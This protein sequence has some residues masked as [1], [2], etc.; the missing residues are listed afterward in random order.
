MGRKKKR[1]AEDPRSRIFCYYCDRNFQTE[2]ML[3][4]HQR[5]KHLRCPTCH[6]RMLSIPS[7]TVH[8]SQMHNVTIKSVPNA[9]PN[10]SDVSVDV[11]GMKGI[12]ESYYASLE[13]GGNKAGRV[14]HD[15]RHPRQQPHA[16]A[17]HA[18]AAAPAYSESGAYHYPNGNGASV[19]RHG[20]YAQYPYPPYAQGPYGAYPPQA[21]APY[22]ASYATSY[23]T[24][25]GPYQPHYAQQP[26][27]A[28]Q[29]PAQSYQAPPQAYNGQQPSYQQPSY[30]PQWYKREAPAPTL[31][32]PVRPS[33]LKTQPGL[34]HDQKARVEGKT[35]DAKVV[36]DNVDVSMEELRAKLPRYKVP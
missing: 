6:K 26:H 28:Y 3:L 7:M 21:G 24:P 14:S 13:Q 30:Q 34:K 2:Q 8:A 15:H 10:R 35:G 32:G 22:A 9:L 29:A 12:P 25:A 18:N 27:V 11:L 33:E 16:P 31:V 20:S 19:A 36:F 4:M 23:A 5:E 17:P 1:A